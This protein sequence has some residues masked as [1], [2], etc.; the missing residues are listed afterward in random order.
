MKYSEIVK[1]LKMEQDE[2][3]DYVFTELAKSSVKK[4]IKTDEYVY[5]KGNIPILLVAHL[6]T[7]HKVKPLEILYD[8]KQGM[9]WSPQGIGGDDRCGIIAILEIIRKGFAPYVLFTTD[10]EIGCVGAGAFCKKE[11]LDKVKFAIEIDRRGNN[12]A[13][14]YDCGNKD[15]QDYIIDGFEFDLDYGSFTDV[16]EIGSTFNIA[17]VNLSAGYYNEHTSSEYIKLHELANTINK[18]VKILKND[19]SRYFDYQ[20]TIYDYC[21]TTKKGRKYFY[22]Q[23]E[24]DWEELDEKEW[25]KWYGYD[26]PKTRAELYQ[27]IIKWYEK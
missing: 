13:V 15:F 22:F 26:K 19:D 12:Q 6:D 23:E 17:I 7:V 5:A 8:A 9:L 14:F 25:K 21:Y 4:I 2:L 27:E 18:V 20:E 3:K 16:C 1:I 11:K 10:E 24:E